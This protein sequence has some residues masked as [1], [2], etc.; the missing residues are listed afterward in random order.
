M[1]G[2]FGLFVVLN[3]LPRTGVGLFCNANEKT[4]REKGYSLQTIPHST[5]QSKAIYGQWVW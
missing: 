4:N 2:N 1:R 3:K 5:A